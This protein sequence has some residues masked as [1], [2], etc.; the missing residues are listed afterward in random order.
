M[1]RLDRWSVFFGLFLIALSDLG[2]QTKVRRYDVTKETDY[3]IVYSLPR[4]EVEAVVRVRERT[5]TPG[6]LSTYAD[7]YLNKKV[8]DTP[9]HTYELVSAQL[10][11]VGRA[12]TTQQYLVSFDRKTLAPFV[13]LT[14]R[15]VLFS[16]NGGMEL[17]KSLTEERQPH[18]LS[19]T[20]SDT[21]LPALPRE[22]A[23]AGSKAK[24]A[25]IAS[26][27]LYELRESLM[28]LV[29]GTVESMPKDGESMRLALEQLRREE[30]RTQRLFLGDTTERISE[31]ILRYTPTKN[32]EGEI[33]LARFSSVAGLTQ[34]D[35]LSGTPLRLKLEI[36][37]RAPELTEK[38]QRKKDK[39]LE[40][41]IVYVQPGLARIS[42]MYEG[43]KLAD[44]QFAVAQLG[45]LQALAPK[46]LQLTPN[47]KTAVYFDIR[48]GAVLD[49][50]QE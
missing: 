18:I 44:E 45:T 42:L 36:T 27:Y 37:E 10:Y 50:R 22:Y 34:A 7:R 41:S 33:T 13:K 25:E 40:H 43:K 15:G 23:Q 11:T 28:N 16:I 39:M 1:H 3:G 30:Y 19:E 24:Q 48:T 26:T 4:T 20:L 6:V 49:I 31:Y 2:A 9:V 32:D 12:D 14:D 17:P 5:Y 29:T 21:T 35:D 46:M 38:E 8:A 47:A